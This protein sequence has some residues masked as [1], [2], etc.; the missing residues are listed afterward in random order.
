MKTVVVNGRFL[1]KRIT[2]VQRFARGLLDA[3]AQ[4]PPA[5]IRVVVAAPPGPL[6]APVPPLE[7]VQDV[8]PLHGHLWEQLRLPF[9]FRR[10]GGDLLWSPCNTGPLAVRR[11]AVTIHDAAVFAGPE[12]F[13]P[14]FRTAYRFLFRSLGRRCRLIL[15]DSEFSRGELALHGV[16][17]E[18][19]IR[20]VPGGVLPSAGKTPPGPG[21]VLTLGSRDPRK[22]VVTLLEGWKRV[23]SAAKGGR[24]LLV[25]G[26]GAAAFARERFSEVP[27]GVR[28][29]GYVAD[30]DLPGLYAGGNLF[31][32]PSLYEGFGLPPLEAMA[33]GVPVLAS[34]IPVHREVLGSS[35]DYFNPRD[36]GELAAKIA[37]LLSDPHRRDALRRAG[38][39]RAEAFTWQKAADR[40]VRAWMEGGIRDA[41]EGNNTN[42]RFG[43]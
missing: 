37:D 33:A 11:Q 25:A 23:P 18:S 7:I 2:G 21:Y 29:A 1:T 14:V 34:D 38:R 36:P 35:A 42:L 5:G 12:W 4:R 31:V 26:G 41:F 16:A 43:A 17:D 39:L 28:F 30:A 8:F 24:T 27:E 9:L 15:T 40:L 32:S 13:S 19:K 6:V 22:N 3:L 20:V 10:L